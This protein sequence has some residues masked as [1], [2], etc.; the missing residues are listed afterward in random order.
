MNKELDNLIQL[1]HKNYLDSMLV[2]KETQNNEAKTSKETNSQKEMEV[3]EDSD[4]DSEAELATGIL[5][6]F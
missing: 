6:V 2:S 3:E 5:F 1:E 4:T